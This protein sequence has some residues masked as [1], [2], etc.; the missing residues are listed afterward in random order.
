MAGK[1]IVYS[2]CPAHPPTVRPGLFLPPGA[3]L[4]GLTAWGPIPLLDD[5]SAT[6]P[7]SGACPGRG[8]QPSQVSASPMRCAAHG[9]I[10]GEKNLRLPL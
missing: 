1:R 8:L 2:T 5:R 7:L 10:A 9:I 6:L 3:G 4:G